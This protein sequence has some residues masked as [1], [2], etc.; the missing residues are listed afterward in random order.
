MN[1][2]TTNEWDETIVKVKI[3]ELDNDQ[4][5]MLTGICREA[6]DKLDMNSYFDMELTV[7]LLNGDADGYR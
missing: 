1:S 7:I 6:L 3:D 4:I 5:S 2:L